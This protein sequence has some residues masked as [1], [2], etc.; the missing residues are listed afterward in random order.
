MFTELKASNFKSW[1]KLESTRLAPVTGFFGANSSGKTSL[2]Q[3]LLLLKQTSESTDRTQPLQLGDAR[4]SIDLG[5]F[6][7]LLFSHDADASLSVGVKWST[8]DPLRV[9]D[10]VTENRTL[11]EATQMGFE[12]SVM[13]RSTGRTE[14]EYFEYQADQNVV[15]MERSSRSHGRKNPEYNLSATID[16]RDDYLRRTQGRV[17]PLPP[18]VKCYGFPDEASAYYQNSGFIGD[19]ELEFDRQFKDRLF[20]L[21][22]LRSSPLRQYQWKGTH[23]DDVGEAGNRAIEALLASR[24]MGR[25]N[26]RAYNALGRATRRITV[27]QHVAE[28]LQELGLVSS[29]VVER[30]APEADIYRV[31]IQQTGDSAPVFLTDVGFG[32][33]QILPVLV[34]LAYV[35]RGSTVIL[36]QPEIHLHPAVQSGLADIILEVAQIRQVQVIVES[37]SEHLLRRLQRRV[38]EGSTSPDDLA[39]YFC[40]VERG[41]SK[42]D[43][44]SL[45]LF[46]EIDNWPRGFF[47]DPL[48]ETAAITRAALLR[49]TGSNR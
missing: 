41:A 43:R 14:V 24:D 21:G 15:R 40:S 18:P 34:L 42:I 26:T 28:W 25:R 48:G 45:N 11:F 9:L 37:H 13:P 19:L 33:S 12:T 5:S 2:L 4:T 20:Y 23:P 7:D 29:F 22:P 38:A 32:V 16:G 35:P 6:T 27:E 17:W 36:E 30:L 3:I 44:L 47:G 1:Q 46:G 49:Q 31:R 10:P 39:L 8:S